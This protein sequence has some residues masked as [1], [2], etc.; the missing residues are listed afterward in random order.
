MSEVVC[1]EYGIEASEL[2]ERCSRQPARAAMAYLARRH[3]VATNG[4]LTKI[5]GVSR[6]ESVANLTRRIE[7]WLASDSKVRK[8]LARLEDALTGDSP[9]Q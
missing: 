9:I 7:A 4:A 1:G 8:Q 2:A 6:A 5:L 3:T